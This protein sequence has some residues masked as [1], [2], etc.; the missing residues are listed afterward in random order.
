M[1]SLHYQSVSTKSGQVG[2]VKLGSGRP[3][4]LLVGYSGTLLHWNSEFIFFLADKFT[5]YLLDNRE[6][7]VSRSHNQSSMLGLAQDV[8]DFIEALELTQPAICG[9][10]MGGIIAQAVINLVPQLVSGLVLIVSQPDYSYTFGNLHYLVQNFRENPTR[11]NREKLTEL[12]FSQ[13]PSLEFRK[14]LAKVIL[15]I[16]NYGYTFTS[17]AQ[18]LQDL[19]VNQWQSNL[20]SLAN[21]LQPVLIITAQDDLVTQPIASWL[22]HQTLANSKLISYS[23][24]GHFCLHRYPRE[25]AQEIC[26]YL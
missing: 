13:L 10:S 19:A 17:Q 20:P 9:W 11:I 1:E 6:V 21:Y 3:L 14:Y 16:E 15:P 18:Q 12:F 26:N 25:L 22:L 24:G 7:G 2:Y 23:R 4:I 5:L 8:V